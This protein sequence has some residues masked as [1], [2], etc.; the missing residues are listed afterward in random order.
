VEHAETSKNTTPGLKNKL[1]YVTKR[2]KEKAK[3]VDPAGIF[4]MLAAHGN[5][6]NIQKE[7]G[8]S[9]A[10]SMVRL[11]FDL[12]I[13]VSISAPNLVVCLQVNN[14][15]KTDMDKKSM[16]QLLIKLL[17][18]YRIQ[19]MEEMYGKFGRNKNNHNSNAMSND[20]HVWNGVCR[21]MFCVV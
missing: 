5:M 13:S 7:V 16:S 18:T 17:L 6:C 8:I 3:D 1:R 14:T 4:V 20:M 11:P 9:V 10:Y 21:L 15:L 2:I 12:L 19:I